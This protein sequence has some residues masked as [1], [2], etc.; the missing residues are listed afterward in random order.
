MYEFVL[1]AMVAHSFFVVAILATDK[2]V[3]AHK[4]AS[5]LLAAFFAINLVL[6][7]TELS[8]AAQWRLHTP[9]LGIISIALAYFLAPLFYLY[10][11]ALAEAEQFDWKATAKKNGWVV[12]YAWL[13]IM[14][15][16]MLGRARTQLLSNGAEVQL[17]FFDLIAVAGI[18]VSVTGFV[19]VSCVFLLKAW[20]VLITH[21]NSVKA[22]FSNIENRTLAWLRASLLLLAFAWS[23]SAI[24]ALSGLVIDDGLIPPV[25][26]AICE[27]MWVYSLSFMA[28]RFGKAQELEM[29][30]AALR[31]SAT[32]TRPPE[33][34]LQTEEILPARSK[35]E[36]T[37][38]DEEQAQRIADKLDKAMDE[39]KLYRNPALTLSDLVVQLRVNSH[40]ISYVLNVHIG[41]SFFDYVN[42]WRVREACERLTD[43]DESVL[44]IAEE[45]GFNSRSTFNAAFKKETGKTPSG[46]RSA[47]K[48]TYTNN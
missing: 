19:I 45:V 29:T 12:A 34:V 1:T 23:V 14:P 38:M 41:A 25:L 18:F 40:R 36:R 11:R 13:P 30:H 33:S 31:E 2:G 37:T 27:A 20:R 7:L 17:T 5:R 8:A 48:V 42:K 28:L 26:S 10:T 15:W 32:Q 6:L 4:I 9:E 16:L 24:D 47:K 43:T 21:L 35:Y 3:S 22:V 46:Y 39:E 44:M